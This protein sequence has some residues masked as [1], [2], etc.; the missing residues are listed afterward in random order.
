MSAPAMPSTFGF[1]CAAH[2]ED[3]DTFYLLPLN[4]DSTG[5]FMPEGKAAVWKTKD[6]GRTWRDIRA[7]LPQSSAYFGVLRQAMATDTLPAAG[8]YFG[9]TGGNVF[10]SSDD[11]ESYR[12]IA[13]YLP[14]ISSI[15]TAVI[16]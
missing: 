2:P 11:G 9:T 15:E 14:R 3:T 6:A 13:A 5:R 10:A 7:G 1:A 16:G 12:E 8:V 4:G